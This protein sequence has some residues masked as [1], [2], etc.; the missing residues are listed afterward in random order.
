M[1]GQSRNSPGIARVRLCGA[2][3]VVDELADALVDRFQL[4]ER[5]APYANRRETDERVYLTVQLNR[6]EGGAS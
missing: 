6:A 1:T 4:L 2:A 5:S 3:D